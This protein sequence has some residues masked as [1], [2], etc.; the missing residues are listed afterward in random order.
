MGFVPKGFY[1]LEKAVLHIA[2]ELDYALWDDTKVP[3]AE[4][5]A[6]EGL[7]E[8]THFKDLE[9][10]VPEIKLRQR[11]NHVAKRYKAYKGAQKLVRGAL[12]AGELRSFLQ[13]EETGHLLQQAAEAWV[14][15]N[16][17][18]WFD[19]GRTIIALD[20]GNIV[21]APK[22]LWASI[23]IDNDSF[24]DWLY[25]GSGPMARVEVRG[26]NW[27]IAESKIEAEFQRWRERQLQGYMPK[28]IEDIEH[29]KE[30]GVSR[31][32]VRKLR[33]KYGGRKRGETG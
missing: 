1:A 18:S 7:G 2:R 4:F 20:D 29:M 15:D 28:A 21:D 3:F 11:N 26:K 32:K 13:I 17:M 25:S 8:K 19:D 6:Y 23:L 14:Q 16:A 5:N 30:L 24:S 27:R 9:K 12:N 22:G 10:L 33:K 31:E